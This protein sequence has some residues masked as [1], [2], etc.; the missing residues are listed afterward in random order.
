MKTI[1][2][3]K[4]DANQRLDKFLT[5]LLRDMPHS[6]I[7]KYIRKKRVKVNGKGSAID[8]T[9]NEGDVLDLYINDEILAEFLEKRRV[10]SFL[11]TGKSSLNVVYEDEG[12]IVVN[13]PA[14]LVVHEGEGERTHTLINY[15]KAYLYNKGE[16]DPEAE[17]SFAPAP[18]HRLDRNTSGLVICAKTAESLR[19]IN[20]KIRNRE[21]KKYYLAL[22]HG[23][24]SPAE[25]V[26]SADIDGKPS[27]TR[28]RIV[29]GKGDLP[30]KC[31][32]LE[33]EL[34]TGRKHQIRIHMSGIGHPIVGDAR[35]GGKK[36][37]G[38]TYQALTAYKIELDGKIIEIGKKNGGLVS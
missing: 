11:T 20:E 19:T 3:G 9:L 4:N 29:S 27:E 1:T 22:V 5:K 33:L 17:Q 10:P 23:K 25:G 13:K 34:I 18:C 12:M 6:L 7:Y 2:I 14:G 31:T 15:V 26:V 21:I 24:P 37:P 16:Y 35:Y 28:Y 32:W 8:C 30:P 38:H 36:M